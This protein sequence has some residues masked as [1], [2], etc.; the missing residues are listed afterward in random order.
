MK[1]TFKQFIV[2]N[3]KKR[4]FFMLPAVLFMGFFVS[5][6][7]EIGWGTDPA[8]FMNLNIANTLGLGLGTTEI[9]VYGI[10]LIFTFIFGP[11]MIGFGTIANMVLIGYVA[12][13]FKW[14]WAK[15]G[16]HDFINMTA[17]LSQIIPIFILTIAGFIIV[18]AIYMNAQMGVAPYDALPAIITNGIKKVPYFL[19]RIIYDFLAM[20]IGIF[21]ASF[22][23]DGIQGS[24]IGSVVISIFLGPVV[25]LVGKPLK[26]IL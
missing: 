26:K 15:N 10:M 20:G 21:A 11:E 22:N 2:P 4:L 17:S 9:I 18:A 25:Q 7:I 24:I 19:V 6:L 14:L 23:P 5:I 13:F 3:F 12:D 8:S 1:F 16:F